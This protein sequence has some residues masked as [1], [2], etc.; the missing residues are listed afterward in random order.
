MPRRRLRPSSAAN[1]ENARNAGKI[2][3]LGRL[4]ELALY[5]TEYLRGKGYDVIAPSTRGEA[6]EAIRRA[7]YD[8]A[9]VTYTLPN[10]LVLEYAQLLREYCPSCPLI[11]IADRDLG[12]RNV[13]PDAIVIADH[14]PDALLRAV[15]RVLA[16]N[17]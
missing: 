4:R 13:A 7:G 6:V 1:D 3:L 11:V 14:G 17:S 16:G 5:R 2:L 10:E 12:D 8:V 15:Q 9:V